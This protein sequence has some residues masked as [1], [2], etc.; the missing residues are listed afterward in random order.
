LLV[1]LLGGVA[2]AQATPP[3][4]PAEL[5]QRALDA[6]PGLRAALARRTEAESAARLTTLGPYAWQLT[7]EAAQRRTTAAGT[8]D[9]WGTALQRGV[10]LPGKAALD[11]DLA[12]LE[13]AQSEAE[14]GVARRRAQVAV[15]E[16]WFACVRASQRA[17]LAQA[18]ADDAER[19]AAAV[20]ARRRAGDAARLDAALA[21]AEAAS[22]GAEAGS[23]RSSAVA[24]ARVLATRLEGASCELEAWDDPPAAAPPAGAGAAGGDGREL[25]DPSLAP[26][27]LAAERAA[28]EA[29][30]A[31]QDRWPDPTL[32][33]RYSSEFGGAEKVGGVS[34]SVP[35]GARRRSAE[36]ARAR[37]SAEVAGAELDAARAA[38]GRERVVLQAELA[39]A[40]AAWARLA[41]A[42]RLQEDAAQLARR[43]FDL[44]ELA[45]SEALLQRRSALRARLAEREAALDAWQ[46]AAL[47][48]AR[49]GGS[50]PGPQ[51]TPGAR[52]GS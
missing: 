3:L 29:E 39:R 7:A 4:P 2:A 9:E 32:G 50:A 1:V 48:E 11:R 27:A 43:A 10:R 17:R 28:R 46:A 31:R 25:A 40:R 6:D 23:A 8:F 15:L 34:I 42:A 49:Y 21:E 20:G 44:G 33:A 51:G 36:A 16:D 13:V 30:R 22:S 47:Y 41:E 35:L 24:A 26:F 5:L 38:A 19:I 37:A 52:A 18:D 12:R 45:L 14:L